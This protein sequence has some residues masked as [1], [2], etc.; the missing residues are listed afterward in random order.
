MQIVRANCLLRPLVA[1]DAESL[2][3]HANDCG[4]WE[5][6]RDRFPHPYALADAESYIAHTAAR[7]VQTSFGIIVDD[8]AIGTIGLMLGDDI[9]RQS[10]EVGYWIGREFWGRGIV[11]EALRAITRHAFET[12]SLDRVF[13]VP[14]ATT[15]RSARVLEKAGYVKE[16]VMRHSAVKDGKLL[17]QLL[18]AAYRDRWS[19]REDDLPSDAR[20]SPGNSP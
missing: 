17:D 13:A 20:S 5:N 7:S 8:Q 18:Y 15:T 10:A 4:V 9:A 2:A 11:V 14:F 16:G 12:L 19:D 1:A 6:L 3:R